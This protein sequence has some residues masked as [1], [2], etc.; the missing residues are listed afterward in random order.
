MLAAQM[1]SNQSQNIKHIMPLDVLTI[2]LLS[3]LSWGSAVV[4]DWACS[5]MCV[6]RR[7]QRSYCTP[8]FCRLHDVGGAVPAL[9][10]VPAGYVCR[11]LLRLLGRDEACA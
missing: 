11:L 10:A 3:K 7:R 5:A 2:V 4:H 8:D 1:T 9:H 6:R